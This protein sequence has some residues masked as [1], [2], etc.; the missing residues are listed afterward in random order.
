M[1]GG[2]ALRT[3][4]IKGED[5]MTPANESA[6]SL[7]GGACVRVTKLNATPAPYEALLSW[8]HTVRYTLRTIE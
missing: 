3:T 1:T 7:E 4:R 2:G 8:D 5:A 6:I